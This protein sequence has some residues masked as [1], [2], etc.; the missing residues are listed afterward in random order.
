VLRDS[1]PAGSVVA[2]LGGEEFAVLLA[3]APDSACGTEPEAGLDV[4]RQRLADLP[5]I[6]PGGVVRMTASFGM[7][8]PLPGEALDSLLRRADSALYRAKA[9]G[10]NRVTRAA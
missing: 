8:V 5:L 6:V 4:M 1:A 3:Q 10:R 9:D 2:R 7:A